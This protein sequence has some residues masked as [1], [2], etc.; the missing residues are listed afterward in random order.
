MKICKNNKWIPVTHIPQM[1]VFTTF[2]F[3]FLLILFDLSPIGCQ[4]PED[5]LQ[6][7]LPHPV[8]TWHC[9]YTLALNGS[10]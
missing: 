6:W 2:A 3:L 1:L 8:H 10:S 4:F 9:A 7:F 5:T